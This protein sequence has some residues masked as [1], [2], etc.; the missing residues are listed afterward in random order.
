[1]PFSAL[2]RV[3]L[4]LEF[5]ERIGRTSGIVFEHAPSDTIFIFRR[6]ADNEKVNWADVATVRKQLDYRGLLPADSFDNLLLK[7]PA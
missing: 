5:A 6:Y 4:D 1:M 3:L 7:K 2:R